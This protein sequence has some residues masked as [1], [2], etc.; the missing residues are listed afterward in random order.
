MLSAKANLST[1]KI[2][3]GYASIISPI[4]GRI[5]LTNVTA[6]NVVGPDSG[7]LATIVSQDPMYVTFP[8][9]QRDFMR[10]TGDAKASSRTSARR[11]AS[12][13]A[14]ATPRPARSI[15]ST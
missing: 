11:S 8:V 15:S 5:G 3:L 7:V 9:S 4:K 2:N 13:T 6:G 1:A 14:R 10:V 12:R